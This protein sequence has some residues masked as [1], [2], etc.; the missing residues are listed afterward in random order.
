MTPKSKE[1]KI[2][3]MSVIVALAIIGSALWFKD[4]VFENTWLYI[5]CF[6]V[7]IFPIVDAFSK[8]K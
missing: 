7:I 1:F 2:V 4:T 8:K 3:I 6:W 5:T